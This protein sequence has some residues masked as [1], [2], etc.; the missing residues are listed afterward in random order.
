M[1]GIIAIEVKQNRFKLLLPSG[2]NK[3]LKKLY[4]IINVEIELSLSPYMIS[5]WSQRQN[6]HPVC[7]I[8]L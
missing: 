8:L 5:R 7:T 2:L 3:V 1:H 4:F 6:N